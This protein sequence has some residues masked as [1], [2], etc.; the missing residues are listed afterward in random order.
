M[1]SESWRSVRVTWLDRPG[2]IARLREAVAALARDHPEVERVVLF[3]SLARGEAVPG[4]DADLLVVLS[5]SPLPFLERIPA[6]TP[7][8]CGIG[9]DV[10]PYT[11]AEL[12]RMMEEENPFVRE[13]LGTGIV[14]YA[15][16]AADSPGESDL[17][18]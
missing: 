18:S 2:T 7:R 9:V 8:G 14:L 16:A 13:A 3:G 10:F 6:Y 15:R 17:Q 4:S 5:D 11:Q 1:P 12:G